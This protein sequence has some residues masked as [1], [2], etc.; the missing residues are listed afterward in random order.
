VI[1]RCLRCNREE[2]FASA[3]DLHL[4]LTALRA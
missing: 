4:A 3:Q 1:L 2:R